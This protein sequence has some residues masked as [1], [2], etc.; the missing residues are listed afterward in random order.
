MTI[1]ILFIFG[2]RPE[3][4]KMPPIIRLLKQTPGVEAR[5]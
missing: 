4:V 2:T 5:V 3:A 1:K